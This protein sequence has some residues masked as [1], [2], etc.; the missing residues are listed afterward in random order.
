MEA[1]YVPFKRSTTTMVNFGVYTFKYLN[2]EKSY[3]KNRLLMLTSKKY[4]GQNM[5]VLIQNGYM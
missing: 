2:T 4:M 5:Y 3:L 1:D